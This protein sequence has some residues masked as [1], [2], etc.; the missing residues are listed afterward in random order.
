MSW[1]RVN[2]TTH[3]SGEYTAVT[4]GRRTCSHAA[5]VPVGATQ[6]ISRRG[7]QLEVNSAAL[8]IVSTGW[9][10]ETGAW[11]VCN[12]L[13]MDM[14]AICREEPREEHVGLWECNLSD[15]HRLVRALPTFKS[16]CLRAR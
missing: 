14:L 1:P 15:V 6:V 16:D 2:P 4:S 12:G 8:S 9:V 13:G 7:G 10:R 11:E 3:L 5:G